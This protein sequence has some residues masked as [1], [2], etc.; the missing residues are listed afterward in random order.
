[1]AIR[2]FRTADGVHWQVWNVVPGR[3]DTE[4]RVGYDRRN[5]EPVF[6]YTGPERRRGADRRQ[7]PQFLS[8]QLASGWLA[9]ECPTEKRRLAPIPQHWEQLPDGELEQ[10]CMAAR[11]V[12]RVTPVAEVTDD[13]QGGG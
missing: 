2:S 5:P 11:P 12:A 8:P 10:L 6:R 13:E 9:F 3:R 1:M 4:R 7:P